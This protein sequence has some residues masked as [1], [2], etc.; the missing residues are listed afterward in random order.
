MAYPAKY[1]PAVNPDNWNAVVDAL[2]GAGGGGNATCAS[3]IIFNDGTDT[4]ARNGS[5]GTID[6]GGPDDEGGADGAD[7]AAVL[8]AAIDVVNAAGGGKVFLKSQVLATAK[9]TVKP[10]V[11]LQGGGCLAEQASIKT[12]TDIDL[13]E[14]KEHSKLSNIRLDVWVSGYTKNAL[15]ISDADSVQKW[16]IKVQDVFFFHPIAGYAVG[17][18]AIYLESSDPTC[19]V[20]YCVFDTVHTWGV[21]NKAV[22]LYAETNGSINGNTFKSLAMFSTAYGFYNDV[23]GV[24]YINNNVF[25]DSTFQEYDNHAVTALYDNGGIKNVFDAI[26]VADVGAAKTSVD[27]TGAT[28]NSLRNCYISGIASALGTVPV[29]LSGTVVMNGGVA[30]YYIHSGS[31]TG[32][33]MEQTVAHGLASTPTK[34][35]LWDIESGAGPYQSSVADATNIYVT[36]ANG[37][38][39]GWEAKV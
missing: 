18:N 8:Q 2:G 9:V 36:A 16:D 20:F 29:D 28:Y 14:M 11:W 19:G 4:Y 39:W 3:Y 6:Y 26:Y 10:Y 27:F 21:W 13:I 17:G 32:T 5:D 30:K 33:A 1:P 15:T 37:Q 23:N 12:T 24:A 31:S 22:N 34:V 38:D 25:R 35:I 7:D